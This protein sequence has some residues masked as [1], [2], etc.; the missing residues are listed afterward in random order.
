MGIRIVRGREFTEYD[1]EAAPRV[2]VV[3]EALARRY[4]PE[5][6][7][8]RRRARSRHHRRRR[9]ATC[10]RP[11]W[12]AR[13]SRRSSTRPAQN[14]TMASDIGMSLVVRTDGPPEALVGQIRAAVREVNPR[15]AIFNVKTMNDV[16]ADSLW[17]LSLYRLAD[18]A[19][20]AL[21]L[22]LAA[23]GL[24][25]V[26]SYTVT[27]RIREF[28]VR[29]ALGSNPA[30]LGRLVLRRGA[31][32]AA[33]GLIVGA[34]VTEQLLMVL[35]HPANR[36]PP[37]RADL[38]LGGSAAA[39]AGACRVSGSCDSRRV[40]QSSDRAASGVSSQPNTNAV[41]VV[42]FGSS[43]SGQT[44]AEGSRRCRRPA[45]RPFRYTAHWYCH[46]EN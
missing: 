9:S 15:L 10:V 8:D 22:V 43:Q 44:R 7:S 34:L 19:V 11:A 26:M 42:E 12:T 16:M 13:P 5:R 33:I 6:G 30:G 35:R 46:I 14:V 21:A 31:W 25:G 2:I 3:N 37:R 17:E 39:V 29:L 45:G 38:C 24:F 41:L 40:G 32:L 18:H 36:R 27:S 20:C 23:I 4:L 28:A 1:D